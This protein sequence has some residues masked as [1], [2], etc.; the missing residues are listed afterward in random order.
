MS[1]CAMFSLCVIVLQC[2]LVSVLI[3]EI[4]FDI[5]GFQ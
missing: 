3:V 1:L 4:L 2:Q 5:N